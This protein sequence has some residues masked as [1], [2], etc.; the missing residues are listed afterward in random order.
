[1]IIGEMVDIGEIIDHLV[2]IAIIGE[3]VDNLV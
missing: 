3:I 1:L 2:D